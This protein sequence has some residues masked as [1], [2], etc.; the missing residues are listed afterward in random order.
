MKYRW[1]MAVP[2]P[3]LCGQLAQSI[4]ISPLLAQCLIN[5]GYTEPEGIACFLEPRLK[6]LADP[7]LLPNMDKAVD[8]L[9]DAREK[10]ELLVVFGDYDVDGVTATALLLE[11]LAGLGW[12][13][14]HYLPH[15]MDEGYGFSQEAVRNCL[16][17]IPA[18]LLLAVDCGSTACETIAALR[19]KG[20]DVIVVDHHQIST[21]PPA[22]VALVNPQLGAAF[23]E[24]CSV[25]LAF[26]LVHALVKRMRELG[27]C[28]GIEPD[29]RATAGFSGPGNDCRPGSPAGREPYI[30]HERTGAAEFDV[31]ARP[32]GLEGRGQ[33]SG[34]L[35]EL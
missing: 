4:G 16:E 6:R 12:K 17:Q 20:I 10:S 34:I 19:E 31:P 18:R 25:G 24:L 27:L 13:V 15:R 26:K 29:L 8:R 7:F 28:C 11:T 9:L 23:H 21:P 32:R 30:C 1:T 35:R 22:A 5:R 33:M 14:A 3:L 2:Q